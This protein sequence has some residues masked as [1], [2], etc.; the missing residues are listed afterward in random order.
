MS[1]SARLVGTILVIGCC[2]A[3][4]P[5]HA[6]RVIGLGSGFVFP[7]G[8]TV[9]GSGN[10]F[11]ADSLNNTVQVIL[12]AG[13]Y[14]TVSALGGGFSGPSGVALDASGNVFVADAGNNAVK[15]ILAAGGYTTVHS[16]GSG[17][18]GPSGVALD[19]SGNVFVADTGNGAVKEILAAGGYTTD[20]TARQRIYLSQRRRGRWQ[21][22]CLC[23]R[24][25]QQPGQEIL[26][27]GGYTAV[28]TLGGGFNFPD[29]VA[30]DASGN[31]FVADSGNLAIKEILA[32]GP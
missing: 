27:A 3:A 7:A 9:D 6:Q 10:V 4:L 32:A 29:G 12:A 19:A 17:F 20:N 23:R 5:A 11:V 30:L 8:V 18:S 21:R 1:I 14:T 15:E 16:L 26:A 13:G 24:Y 25:R 31:V 28:N 2:L 22:Q